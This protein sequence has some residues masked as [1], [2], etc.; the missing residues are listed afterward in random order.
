[1]PNKKNPDPAELVRGRAARVI[2][3]LTGSLALLKGLP[4]A[5]Q[6]DLQEDKP[7]LFA[8]VRAL[9]DSLEVMAGLVETLAIDQARMREAADEG[10]TTATAVADALVRAGLP[11][12]TAHHVVGTLVAA[13]EG[14][15]VTL[16]AVTDDEI[17][18]ALAGADDSVASDLVG[19]AEIGAAIRDAAMVEA[20]LAAL[21]VH[22]GTAPNRVLEQLARAR[23]R[24]GPG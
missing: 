18:S 10:Y 5:Y 2:G 21:D 4:L 3:E 15:G 17:A 20:A 14:R 1:M 6:R 16:D 12:R 13:A 19:N 8:S 23:A 24:L 9:E 7:P 22:G 11:F